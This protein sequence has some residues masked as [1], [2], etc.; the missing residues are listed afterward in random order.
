M[1][2]KYINVG[3]WKEH[4]RAGRFARWVFGQPGW[5]WGIAGLV[6]GFVLI[7]PLIAAVLTTILLFTLLFAVLAVANWVGNTIRSWF[8]GGD[9]RKNVRVVGAESG[10]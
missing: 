6:A 9:G 4:P 1:D 2:F 3:A 10:A 8:D 5:V 7:W